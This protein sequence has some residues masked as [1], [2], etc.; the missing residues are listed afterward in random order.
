MITYYADPDLT[1]HLVDFHHR[2]EAGD[3]VEVWL[4]EGDSWFSLGGATS[5]LLMALGERNDNRLIVSCAYP[6]DTLKNMSQL[7]NNPFQMMLSERFGQKWDRILLS[8][9]G[10]DVLANIAGVIVD[11]WV[12]ADRLARMIERVELG[13]RRMILDIRRHKQTARVYTHTYDYPT[14][15]TRKRWWGIGPWVGPQLADMDVANADMPGVVWAVIDDLARMLLR[16][17]KA[18]L[19]T[20]VDTRNTLAA[21]GWGVFGRHSDWANEIHPSRAGYSRLARKWL[22]VMYEQ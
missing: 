20:C 16:L 7:G 21:A 22:Q 9:G 6:G 19:V 18:G 1:R 5:N 10:N 13:F 11:E 2:K 4:A 14:T 15:Q 17:Q 8:A 12:D 3:P